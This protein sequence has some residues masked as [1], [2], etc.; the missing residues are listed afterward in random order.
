MLKVDGKF[1]ECFE[2]KASL[3][4]E[5]YCTCLIDIYEGMPDI[6]AIRNHGLEESHDWKVDQLEFYLEV[7]IAKRFAIKKILT[8]LDKLSIS[9][10]ESKTIVVQAKVCMWKAEI[11]MKEDKYLS[12]KVDRIQLDREA[13]GV[14]DAEASLLAK[15]G[16]SDEP[17]AGSYYSKYG[18][19]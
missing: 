4:V 7:R 14:K 8:E 13:K 5:P 11:L 15:L 18:P 17:V 6:V 2:I 16:Y 1:T 9:I 19:H 12:E 10:E 3:N